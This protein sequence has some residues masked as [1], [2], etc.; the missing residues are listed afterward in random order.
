MKA[1]D[2]LCVRCTTPEVV[3]QIEGQTFAETIAHLGM[4]LGVVQQSLDLMATVIRKNEADRELAY[5]EIDRAWSALFAIKPAAYVLFTEH[6]RWANEQ[7]L[8]FTI[9]KPD[10]SAGPSQAH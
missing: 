6:V 9:E 1:A 4:V 5:Q 7:G 10:T 3:V 2:V 8:R